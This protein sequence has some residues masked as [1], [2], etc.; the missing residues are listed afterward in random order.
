[1]IY[2]DGIDTPKTA[3]RK[4]IL[5]MLDSCN[6]EEQNFKYYYTDYQG[7]VIQYLTKNLFSFVWMENAVK[8]YTIN[9]KEK[10]EYKFQENEEIRQEIQKLRDVY[11]KFTDE[12]S[13]LDELYE[14]IVKSNISYKNGI[15]SLYNRQNKE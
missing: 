1:M 2:A 14:V 12:K 6:L 5:K 4:S 9:C 7:D 13:T 8:E 15:E 10:L 11:S 3:L